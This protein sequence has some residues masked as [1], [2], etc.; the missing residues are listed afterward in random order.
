[1]AKLD[2]AQISYAMGRIDQ[3]ANAAATRIT[4]EYAAPKVD[5]GTL[6]AALVAKGFVVNDEYYLR[7]VAL[8]PTAADVKREET[9]RKLIEA[10]QPAKDAAKDAIMLSD[11]EEVANV[12]A[13]L[14]TTLAKLA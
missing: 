9:K 7:G 3:V 1:M 4:K 14:A 11:S 12:L 5:N 8:K 13:N 6:A 10:I 2:K